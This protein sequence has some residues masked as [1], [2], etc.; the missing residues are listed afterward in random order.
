MPDKNKIFNFN[1]LKNTD[2]NAFSI[3]SILRV[4]EQIP[5]EFIYQYDLEI[6]KYLDEKLLF[7][8][9]LLAKDNYNICK[10]H[11]DR[12]SSDQLSTFCKLAL[13][14][15]S[16]G[17]KE[18]VQEVLS[19]GLDL[20]F[21][22]SKNFPKAKIILNKIKESKDNHK[23]ILD[24]IDKL[25]DSLIKLKVLLWMFPVAIN[26]ENGEEYLQERIALSDESTID[27]LIE[28]TKNLLFRD[29]FK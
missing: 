27:I 19:H 15:G 4:L 28:V 1:A 6:K 10:Y 11:L 26:L 25:S 22:N 9:I 12:L 2:K 18:N 8:D 24:R 14:L 5:N 29:D 7:N 17:I 16:Y 13:S 20:S 23:V 3:E 21:P